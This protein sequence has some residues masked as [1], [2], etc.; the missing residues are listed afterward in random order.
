MFCFKETC[1][2]SICSELP[3]KGELI[4]GKF[5]KLANPHMDFIRI[6]KSSAVKTFLYHLLLL[7]GACSE[8][9]Y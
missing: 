8:N 2:K 3:C 9:R 5:Y 4:G 7:V 1:H 6:F